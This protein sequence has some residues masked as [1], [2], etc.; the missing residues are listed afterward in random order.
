M[1]SEARRA[2]SRTNGCASRPNSGLPEF[3]TLSWPKSDKSDFGGPKTPAGKARSAQ[4][5]LRHGLSR[6]AA[7]DPVWANAIAA[8]ARAIA[9]AGADIAALVGARAPA[10]SCASLTRPT[11]V[12]ARLRRAMASPLHAT[13]Q[14]AVRFELAWRIAAAQIDVARVRCARCDLLSTVPLDGAAIARAAALD[15]YERRALSCRKAAMRAFDAAFAPAPLAGA[16]LKAAAASACDAANPTRPNLAEQTQGQ[17]QGQTQVA[18]VLAER[19]QAAKVMARQA[20]AGPGEPRHFARTNPTRSGCRAA[21]W[22]NE[23][24]AH[25]SPVIDSAERTRG[26]RF[27]RVILL[28]TRLM[29]L[30]GGRR[31]TP[32]ALSRGAHRPRSGAPRSPPGCRNTSRPAAESPESA[33]RWRRCRSLP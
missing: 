27:V 7:L 26:Y 8:L 1:T 10:R 30:L 23:P 20:Q 14:T 19:T 33:R 32:A 28:I 11:R 4:N 13:V 16:D 25:G 9:G 24:D 18:K 17:T 29:T 2:A 3:G 15:R 21:V 12:H 6:P 22:P 31:P 5:A